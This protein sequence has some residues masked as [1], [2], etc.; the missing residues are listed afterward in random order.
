V[1]CSCCG[2]ANAAPARFCGGCGKPLEAIGATSVE[3]ERRHV[4]VL[5]CDLVGSTPLSH[6]LDAEDF[7]DVLASYQR[8]CE[9]VVRRHDGFVAQYRGDSIEVYFGYP[10]AHEDDAS[11]AVRCALEI[12]QA[13]REL[14]NTSKVDLQVRIGIDSGRVVVG[15]LGSSGRLE[16]V[17]VGETPNIAARAQAEAAPGEVV[18]TDSLWRLLSGRFAVDPMGPRN[19]KGVER[20][21]ELFKVLPSGGQ[22]PGL[23]SRRTPFIGRSS[24]RHRVRELWACAKCGKAQFVL[25]RGEPGIG[26]SRLLEVLR[27][28]LADELTDVLV[29]RCTPFT[30]NS[31]LHPFVEL[32]SSRLGL[33]GGS[34]DERV[35]RIANRMIELGLPP[36]ETV[37]LLASILSIPVDPKWSTPALSPAR[38]RQR[39]MEILI[40]ASLALT[41]RGPVLF[42]IEDLHWADPS[43]VELLRRLVGSVRSARLMTLLT[44]RPEFAPTWVGAAHVT[45][46]ELEGLD[47]AESET[48][49]R[50]VAHDKP[51]PPEV[52]WK[53]RERAAGN[54]LFLEE[55]TR[56]VIESGAL[57]QREHAWELVGTLSAEVVPTSMEAS[58][59]AR[60]DRLGEARPLF[61]LAATLGR[62]FSY[63]LLMAVAKSSEDIVRRHLAVIL[64]S[65]LILRHG[66]ASPVYTFKHALVRDAAYDSLLRVTRQRYHA[67][68]AEVLVARFPQ[69]VQ[70]RPELL[71]HHLSGAGMHADAAAH[72]QAAAENAA[73]RSAVNEAVGYLRHALAAL[74]QLPQ[75]MTCMDRELSVLAAMAPV[76]AAAHGW[77]APEIGETCQR[78]IELARR[79][80]AK[81]R[82][83]PS[84]WGLWTNQ[85]VAGRLHEAID[86]ATQLLTM[87]L[88]GADPMLVIIGRGATCYTRYYRGEYQEA[89]AEAEVG[90][91]QCSF[92]I[93]VQIARRF[94]IS[95]IGSMLITKASALWMRGRQDDGVAIVND[96]IAH[97]RS[98]QHP[99]SIATVL[100]T[101][102]F[103]CFYDRD[104]K[105]L[106]EFADEVYELSRAEGF[107]M[108]TAN[109]GL[110]RGY[111]RI[112]LGEVDA[113]VAEVLEW[114]ALF[115]QTGSGVIE[116]S[117]T[118]MLCEAMHLAGRSE[119]ALVVSREGE[120]R[121]EA[122]CV[123]VMLPEIFRTRGNIFL[124]LKRLEEAEEA[125]RQAVA[126]ARAQGARSLELRALTALL[127]FRF[128]FGEPGDLPIELRRTM[129]AMACQPERPDLVA[130]RSLVARMCN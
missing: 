12:L 21:V 76:L 78:A 74:E 126:C 125:F 66:D 103:F 14:A 70:N 50:K 80:E 19:L 54:P 72:W 128:K 57:V 61:Q 73:K 49:I 81:D 90:L 71:A 59:M 99:P 102:M 129:G 8:E 69:L 31:V 38:A 63:D 91:G 55:I 20:P 83:Y 84:F 85:F 18:V 32:I 1:N 122:G 121:A 47:P 33:E 3:A 5:F 105:S 88:T 116:G 117:T 100:A 93:D 40:E 95:A 23:N 35:G 25:L 43:S 89:I 110:H 13:I 92:E 115:R 24:Q 60:I 26:K 48:F 45:E 118:S 4:C 42:V 98:L 53:I 28:E 11:R 97:A 52:V 2:F 79:I 62:E 127:D 114:G 56:S 67:R 37:P 104:W 16:R 29:A 107:A 109:A 113:G 15:T 10:R 64:Q 124:D 27:A 68:I 87:A 17:A 112:G 86:S 77:A 39:T 130:A 22:G 94:Q 82:M 46:I 106:F 51:P 9:A 58:L 120:Q 34:A 30:T 41:R 101:V 96:L 75:D 119:E 108:W 36:A 44:A 7:R 65:G 6:Q 111:A 123:R